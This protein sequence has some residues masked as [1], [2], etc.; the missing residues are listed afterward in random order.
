M[1]RGRPVR[2]AGIRSARSA[3]EQSDGQAST[4]EPL[5]N[6]RNLSASDA[7]S[8]TELGWIR[9]K[10]KPIR[11]AVATVLGTTLIAYVALQYNGAFDWFDSTIL[12]RDAIAAVRMPGV[13]LGDSEQFAAV[14][15]APLS[16][17]EIRRLGEYDSYRA[18]LASSRAAPLGRAPVGY[19]IQGRRSSDVVIEQIEAEVVN[20]G[21]TPRAAIIGQPEIG[22]GPSDKILLGFNLDEPRPVAR[23]IKSDGSLGQ[24]FASNNY[25]T[26]ARDENLVFT[27]V[28]TTQRPI[29][30]YWNIK[31]TVLARTGRST[32]TL[33]SEA[34]FVVAGAVPEYPTAFFP[35]VGSPNPSPV[36]SDELCGGSCV[37]YEYWRVK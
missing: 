37:D 22:G 10:S 23:V 24:P 17:Q 11:R 6:D 7:A 31:V 1:R 30:Y 21:P 14:F 4:N 8:S 33:P 25:V 18:V 29:L 3:G 20:H 5:A 16:S 2:V 9:R 26:L 27:F 28:G 35:T 15:P 34:P 36:S 19:T 32:I 13:T 12:R